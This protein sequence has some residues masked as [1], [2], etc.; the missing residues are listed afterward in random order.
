M[1]VALEHRLAFCSSAALVPEEEM[2]WWLYGVLLD[3]AARA[4]AAK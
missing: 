2:G 4:A 1:G 3:G